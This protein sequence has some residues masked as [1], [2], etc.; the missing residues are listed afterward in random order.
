M[1]MFY[2]IG[3]IKIGVKYLPPFIPPIGRIAIDIVRCIRHKKGLN[4]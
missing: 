2:R 1:T 3:G 4:H